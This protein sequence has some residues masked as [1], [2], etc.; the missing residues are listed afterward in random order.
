MAVSRKSILRHR[1][2]SLL[3]AGA[4]LACVWISTVVV[5]VERGHECTGEECPVCQLVQAAR[6]TLAFTDCLPA[7]SGAMKLRAVPAAR[8]FLRVLVEVAP[9]TLVHRKIRLN[10]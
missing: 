6:S 3:L 10:N 4:L 5:L 9:D 7:T 1:L 2:G 8:P